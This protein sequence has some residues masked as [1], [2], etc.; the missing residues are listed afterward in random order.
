MIIFGNLGASIIE[1]FLQLIFVNFLFLPEYDLS[2][3][4]EKFKKGI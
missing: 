4:D 1:A 3:F 2:S